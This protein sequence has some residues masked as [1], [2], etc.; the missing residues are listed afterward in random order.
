MLMSPANMQ[1]YVN[2][3]SNLLPSGHVQLSES[4]AQ[5]VTVL[6]QEAVRA[7]FKRLNKIASLHVFYINTLH[8]HVLMHEGA[9]KYIC[10]PFWF[11]DA[12]MAPCICLPYLNSSQEMQLV[13]DSTFLN[14]ILIAR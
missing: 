13:R 9:M 14:Q 2:A 12:P 5:T 7:S 3:L 11:C 4:A 8:P 6:T 1:E 10:L